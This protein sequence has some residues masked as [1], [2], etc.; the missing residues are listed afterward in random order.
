MAN[1]FVNAGVTLSSTSRTTIYTCPL[2]TAAILH[3]IYI[4]N[5][6]GTNSVNATIEVTIDGG[7]T[8]K[9]VGYLLPVPAKSTL[10]LDKPINLEASDILAVTA[11]AASDLDVF[12]SVLQIT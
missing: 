9:K 12:M 11:S 5:I 8:Y 7:T 6:D 1:T 3:A 10:V 4:S 2:S